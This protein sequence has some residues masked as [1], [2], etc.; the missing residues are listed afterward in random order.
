MFKHKRG[1]TAPVFH[2]VN[3]DDPQIEVMQT[4]FKTLSDSGIAFVEVRKID[5]ENCELAV[6]LHGEFSSEERGQILTEI[7]EIYASV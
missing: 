1:Y 5:I 6:I 2:I 4:V 7:E 3:A